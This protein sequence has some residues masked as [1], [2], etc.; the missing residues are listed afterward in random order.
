[1]KNIASLTVF[2]MMMMIDSGLLFWGYPVRVAAYIQF[3]GVTALR[4]CSCH[5]FVNI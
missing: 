4:E 2:N 1:M 5:V 3:N